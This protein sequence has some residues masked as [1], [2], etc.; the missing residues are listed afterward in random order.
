MFPLEPPEPHVPDPWFDGESFTVTPAQTD[1]LA[2]PHNREAEEAVL[3]AVFI[4]PDLM[5]DLFDILNP[6]D[7]YI[8]R[9]QWIWE[10]MVQ[11]WVDQEP[12]DLLTV[13]NRLESQGQ[14]SEV[15]GPAYLTALVNQVPHTMNAESYA[16]IVEGH[17]VRRKM[18]D[19]ANRIASLAYNEKM[20][21]EDVIREADQ[22]MQ[23]RPA[24]NRST[25]QSASDAGHELDERIDSGKPSSVPMGFPVPDE[26]FGGFPLQAATMFLGDFSSGKTALL[27]QACEQFNFAGGRPL[28]VTLEEPGWKMVSRRVFPNAGVNLVDFRRGVLVPGQVSVLK[29]EIKAYMQTHSL[30][31]FDHQARTTEGIRRSVRQHR[32]KLVIVDDLLHVDTGRKGS[33]NETMSLIRTMVRLKDIAIDEN[34]AMVVIHHLST[35][36]SA[37]F[38]PSL[39]QNK[40]PTSNV[41]PSIHNIPWASTLRFT[42]DM[43]LAILPDYQADITADEVEMILWTLKDKGGG[44]MKSEIHM[45]YDKVMQWWYDRETYK[46]KVA[47]P[48]QVVSQMSLIK[49]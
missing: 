15:G 44:R 36:D 42:I 21:L 35:E 22:V 46:H 9:H 4:N 33:E 28:Y 27:L 45:W 48:T 11:M 20:P 3:G 49:P 29:D 41:P 24:P 37:R 47:H 14:L 38:S 32:A 40:K 26:D 30:M 23:S 6:V 18:I 19:A 13:S 17:S 8:H 34:C 39:A 1:S 16:R 12:I 31:A 7:F 5:P 10:A 43:W 25:L 2:V